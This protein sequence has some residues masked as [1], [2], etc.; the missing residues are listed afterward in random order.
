[1]KKSIITLAIIALLAAPAFSATLDWDN[2]TGATGY[3]VRYRVVGAPTWTIVPNLLVSEMSIDSLPL[4]VDTRY[5][6][7][8]FGTAGTPKSYSA[9]SDFIR[10]TKEPAPIVIETL[11][12]PKQLIINFAE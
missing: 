3:E 11:A 9:G 7:Q 6:F 1:M 8:V 2:S 10:W 5:E 4:V 12:R